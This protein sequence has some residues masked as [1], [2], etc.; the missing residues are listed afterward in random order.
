MNLFKDILAKKKSFKLKSCGWLLLL[1]LS[2]NGLAQSG[3]KTRASIMEPVIIKPD[4]TLK[5][6]DIFL[7]FGSI[8]YAA[9]YYTIDSKNSFLEHHI[10]YQPYVMENQNITVELGLADA[11][12]ETGHFFTPTDLNISYQRIFDP[13][14]I[15]EIGYQGVG[16]ALKLTLPTGRDTYFS[17]FD[18]WTIEPRVGMQWILRNINW[19]FSTEA[20]YNYSFASLPGSSPRFSYVRMEAYFG[21]ENPTWWIFIE[22]DYR[23]IPTTK[24]STVLMGVS[25]GYKWSNLFSI[26]AKAKP[27]IIGSNFYESLYSIGGTWF[28]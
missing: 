14:D 23:F 21:F 12:L 6:N 15:Q 19:L 13:K 7:S 24:K 27:R 8:N 5:V 17:G 11:Y 20:R 2:T 22:P 28:F 18:S 16:F 4:T 9:E 1:E 10:T 26:N 3:A 25:A